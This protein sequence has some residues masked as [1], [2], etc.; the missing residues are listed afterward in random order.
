MANNAKLIRNQLRIVAKEEL[1][2]YLKSEVLESINKTLTDVIGAR[3]D[4]VSK[5]VDAALLN[6]GADN[7]KFRTAI[8]SDASLQI[9]GELLGINLS[10]LAFMA[11]LKDELKLSEIVDFDSKIEV[12]KKEI[13]VKLQADAKAQN[14]ADQAAKAQ[15]K[16]EA[17]AANVKPV[18]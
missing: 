4:T 15:A 1:P 18:V 10:L 9:S 17:E 8:V 5:N 7:K 14:D 16:A 13:E 3:L 6:M 12:K 11:V 2:N